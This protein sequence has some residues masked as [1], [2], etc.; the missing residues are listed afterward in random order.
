[1]KL[2]YDQWTETNP[3]K[4]G[5]TWKLDKP[6][7]TKE[8]NQLSV[9]RPPPEEYFTTGQRR[10]VETP[11]HLGAQP[12]HVINEALTVICHVRIVGADVNKQAALTT[13]WNMMEEVRRILKTYG[14]TV[15]GVKAYQ[16]EDWQ[17]DDFGATDPLVAVG[18]AV[19]MALYFK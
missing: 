9:L 2:L 13:R 18:K 17:A 8:G 6:D 19:V 14:T 11:I 12:M 3:S 1:M 7:P 16:L 10:T 5:I 15:E 4:T